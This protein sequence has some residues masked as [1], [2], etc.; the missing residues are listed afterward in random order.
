MLTV[1]TVNFGA[2]CHCAAGTA[3]APARHSCCSH[4]EKAPENKQPCNDGNG[5]SGMHAVKFNLLE[6]QASQTIAPEPLFPMTLPIRLLAPAILITKTF[7]EIPPH[8]HPPPDRQVL[9]QCF[10]I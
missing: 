1:F 9:F 5:C 2:I 6:K 10:L 3:A 8:K 4:A 7:P